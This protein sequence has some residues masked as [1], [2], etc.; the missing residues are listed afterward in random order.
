LE[1]TSVSRFFVNRQRD[2]GQGLE[3]KTW[4]KWVVTVDVDRQVILSQLARP[5]PVNDCAGLPVP[6][7]AADK[8][9]PIGTVLADAE[10]DSE[11][12]HRFCREELGA[13]SIIPAKR[14][15]K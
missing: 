10:F 8:I 2:R 6:V 11:R 12:N 14:G 5:A 3:W 13:V 4:C 9:L 7:S 1:A 15:K